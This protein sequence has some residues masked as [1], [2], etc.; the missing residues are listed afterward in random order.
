MTDAELGFQHCVFYPSKTVGKVKYVNNMPVSQ[1]YE[2]CWLV[3]R[4]TQYFKIS[5]E[6]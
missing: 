4:Q 1:M 3:A 2:H 5:T 6:S